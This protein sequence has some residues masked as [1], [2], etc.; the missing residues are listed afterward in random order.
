[1]RLKRFSVI[2]M[3][4]LAACKPPTPAKQMDSIQSWLATAELDGDAWLRHAAP[5]NYSRQTLELSRETL[6][7]VSHD[8]LSS[9][10]PGVDSAML[11]SVLI[12]SRRHIG[13][14]SRFIEAKNP[15]AFARQLDSLRADQKIVKRIA[16]SIESG[17]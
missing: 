4:L 8:L 10:P 14:M 7:Q 12:R 1:M 5:D 13:Q 2:A 15:P 11:D 16:N 9:H 6:L 17:R 3:A